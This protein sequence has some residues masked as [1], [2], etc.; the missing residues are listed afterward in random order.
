MTDQSRNSPSSTTNDAGEPQLFRS[1]G[2]STGIALVVGAAIGSGIFVK[3]GIIASHLDDVRLILLAW[4]LG[5]VLALFGGLCF[6]EL[7]SM[8]PRAGGLY[9][10]LREAYGPLIG[11]LFGWND[12]LFNRPAATGALSVVF[13]GSLAQAV[14]WQPG[15]IAQT[16]AAAALI[17]FLAVINILGVHWGGRMQVTTTVVKAGFLALL[18]LLPVL[19]L[20]FGRSTFSVAN[21]SSVVP[22][23]SEHSL[24]TR[25]GIV[26]LAV[27]WAYNGWHGITPAAEEIRRPERTIPIALI[28]GIAILIVLYVGANVAYHGVM[29][30]AEIVSAGEHTAEVMLS[31]LLG[32]LGGILM[33]GVIMCSSLGSIN[34][35]LMVTPRISYAMARDGLFVRYLNDVH[36]VFGTPARSVAMQ[37]AMAI[38]L[39]GASAVLVEVDSRLSGT[40]MF[41]LLSNFVV[42]AASLF[43]VLGVLAVPVLRWKQPERARPY[44]TWGYPIVPITFLVIYA[45]FLSEVYMSRPVEAHIGLVLIGCGIPAYLAFAIANRRG[46]QPD[47]TARP[48]A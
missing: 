15:S 24:L 22:C 42:F 39:V 44:R 17:L 35:D 18:I 8:L 34:T 3:P 11:F 12:V 27:M 6:A 47:Q 28:S 7:A 23:E 4:L 21:W 2:L 13:V 31:R 37:A 33:A 1:L 36:R 48:T 10:Y 43:Y 14:G 38:L 30:H 40:S 25:F 16:L 46:R 29:S 45:W 32:P 5:G 20:P 9:A 41:E 26:M 19:L